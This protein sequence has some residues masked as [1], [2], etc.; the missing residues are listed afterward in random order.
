MAAQYKMAPRIDDKKK[1]LWP[2]RKLPGFVKP[3]Q[4]AHQINNNIWK[5]PW[6]T[7]RET[8][9][10][11]VDCFRVEPWSVDTKFFDKHDKNV[12]VNRENVWCL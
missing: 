9:L 12:P 4:T 7:E 5:T 10:I 2:A 11:K 8:F 1:K 6:W 3:G